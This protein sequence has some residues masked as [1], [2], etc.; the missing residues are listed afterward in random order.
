[1]QM[2]SDAAA[3]AKQDYLVFRLADREYGI[4][5]DKVQE[6][7]AYNAVTP[8]SG[9]PQPIAGAIDW[10][11]GRLPVLNLHALLVP[12]GDCSDECGRLSDVVILNH[13]GL[14][15]GLAVDCV[16]DVLSLAPEQIR[17][18]LRAADAEEGRLTGIAT[19]G[20]RVV[21][22]LDTGRLVHDIQPEPEESTE[23]LA[24]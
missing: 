6:L 22:L 12:G 24:A 11:S 16:V 7:S 9:A 3:A 21:A 10:K 2:K 20:K 13:D 18:T 15:A 23:P 5:L 1:M 14:A 4:A 17:T 19:Q 8:L